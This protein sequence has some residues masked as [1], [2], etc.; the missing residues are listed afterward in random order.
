V[1]EKTTIERDTGVIE[2][3]LIKLAYMTQDVIEVEKGL[4]EGE[5]VVVELYQ[6]L[7]DKEKVE[8]VEVLEI[9]Y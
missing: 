4:E 5:L 6:E 7:Q 1:S 9:L 8:I 2:V 3:R